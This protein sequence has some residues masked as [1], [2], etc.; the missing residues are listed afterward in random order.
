MK[1][2]QVREKENRALEKEA[3]DCY[4]VLMKKLEKKDN[5]ILSLKERIEKI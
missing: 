3:G 1:K 2:L 5:T 4:R